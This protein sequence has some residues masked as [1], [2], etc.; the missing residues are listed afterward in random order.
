MARK[1][2]DQN[3]NQQTMIPAEAVAPIS[4]AAAAPMTMIHGFAIQ[5]LAFIPIPKDDLRKQAEIPLLLLD[6]NEG[7]KTLADLVPH[8][9]GIE[10]RQQH[11]GRR[12]SVD[13][14]NSWKQPVKPADQ[15]GEQD[16]EQEHKE[17]ADQT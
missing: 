5:V 7:K 13:E 4:A 3:A 10:F 16:G 12:V 8:L 9:R 11:T 1:P 17:D 6:I 15:S 14:V 2:N